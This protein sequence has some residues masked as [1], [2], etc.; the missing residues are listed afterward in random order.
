MA[1]A[2]PGE[3]PTGN[4]Y[5]GFSFLNGIC[6]MLGAPCVNVPGLRGPNDLPIGLL[7]I[8]WIGDDVRTLAAANWMALRLA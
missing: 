2:S 6:T 7:A 3:A 5:T 8:G 1:H 4:A